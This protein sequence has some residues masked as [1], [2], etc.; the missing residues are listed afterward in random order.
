MY[1]NKQ[2]MYKNCLIVFSQ[3][4][5]HQT[6]LMK[7][8]PLSYTKHKWQLLSTSVT[9]MMRLHKHPQMS[10]QT[11]VNSTT[12]LL[13]FIPHSHHYVADIERY[14]LPSIQPIPHIKLIL[15]FKC[16]QTQ[17]P[18][19]SPTWMRA[20]AY[21]FLSA[22]ML[23]DYIRIISMEELKVYQGHLRSTMILSIRGISILNFCNPQK[24][25][26]SSVP[27]ISLH[28]CLNKEI[29][30]TLA[31]APSWTISTTLA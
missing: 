1:G 10:T 27:S 9:E 16:C 8:E 5:F 26:H 2:F 29:G 21:E 19:L 14:H 4:I 24:L 23:S 22:S 6:S 17:L 13:F 7:N 30:T 31:W 28:L 12:P 20:H 15:G 18:L 3:N 25:N 11:L